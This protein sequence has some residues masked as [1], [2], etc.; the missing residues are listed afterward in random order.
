MIFTSLNFK[1]LIL[2]FAF[3]SA[4]ADAALAASKLSDVLLSAIQNSI[5]SV[6]KQKGLPTS[7]AQPYVICKDQ[8]YALC[9]NAN[10]F[11][12]QEVAYAKCQ[13]KHGDSIS[14]PPLYYP[15]GT[16]AKNICN[17]NAEGVGNGYMASTYSLP[18][19]VVKSNP[20][21]DQAVYTCP[22]GSVSGY[23][24]CD[25][26]TCFT[27][28]SGKS[29]PGVGDV[30]RDEIICSCPITK[31]NSSSAPFGFQFIGPY[32]CQQ[33]IFKACSQP[34]DNGSIIPVGSPPGAGRAL[35]IQLSG[36]D[37]QLNECFLQQ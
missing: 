14:A 22:G 37:P 27:S 20:K 9:A 23:A 11:V 15:P 12:F 3:L 25:G 35:T 31:T 16:T 19:S 8:T 6:A 26:G 36:S 13:I 18:P 5:S 28:T 4:H 2:A 29:F 30:G 1:R 34:V 21:S 33:E 10:S 24:Q 17:F 7:G 32:P